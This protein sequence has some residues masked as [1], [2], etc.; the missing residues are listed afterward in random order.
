M[1]GMDPVQRVANGMVKIASAYDKLAKAIK[2][3]SSALN[4]LDPMRVRSFTVLTGNIAML[5]ALDST[6]FSNMLKV[7]ES[8]S[9]V[10]ANMLQAQTAELGK[11]PTVKT[12][13]ATGAA[14]QTK[15]SDESYHKDARGE[16]QLQKLDKMI[17]YLKALKDEAQGINAFLHNPKE[18][19]A[20]M[21]SKGDG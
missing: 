20:D 14:V 4:G 5:S 15:K 21:G 9:G 10:F 2:N 19:N 8:R 3:F 16:T 7:L 11:R 1:L 17:F 12:Q 6:M 13:G 18:T